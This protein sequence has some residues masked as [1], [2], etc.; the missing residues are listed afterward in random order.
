MPIPIF[1]DLHARLDKLEQQLGQ[2][3]VSGPLFVTTMI[4]RLQLLRLLV[5]R[6]LIYRDSL[7]LDVLEHTSNF[8]VES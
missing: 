7:V 1:E 4:D 8:I 6:F 5:F 3:R 2:M